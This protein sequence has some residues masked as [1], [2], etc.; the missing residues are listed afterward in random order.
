MQ[1]AAHFT[2][3]TPQ[4]RRANSPTGSADFRELSDAELDQVGGGILPALGL[5]AG[6][7]GHTGALGATGGSISMGVGAAA[8][9]V[10][11]FGLGYATFEFARAYGGGRR[12]QIKS[13][14]Q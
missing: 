4:V 12:R 3:F 10:T 6:V 8:H 13:N 9:V 7:I 1:E 14:S 11:G 5:L 2:Q